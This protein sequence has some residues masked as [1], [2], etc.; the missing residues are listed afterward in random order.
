MFLMLCNIIC[1]CM[2]YFFCF[3]GD[4]C[5]MMIFFV[6]NNGNLNY[7]GKVI[8]IGMKVNFLFSVLLFC[9]YFNF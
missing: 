5:L 9:L 7:F 8:S 4:E 2:E 3:C 1:I 6:N